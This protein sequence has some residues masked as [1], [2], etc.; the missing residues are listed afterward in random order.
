[1]GGCVGAVVSL[2]SVGA[3]LVGVVRD[4]VAH[5]QVAVGQGRSIWHLPLMK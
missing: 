4:H 2:L 3:S 5:V 1:M